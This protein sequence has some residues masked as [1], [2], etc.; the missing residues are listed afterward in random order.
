MFAPFLAFQIIYMR[1]LLFGEW[2]ECKYINS[3]PHMDN[4]KI[5]QSKLYVKP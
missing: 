5:I 2:K 4:R 3:V 1:F